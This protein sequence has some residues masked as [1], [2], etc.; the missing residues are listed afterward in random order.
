[1]LQSEPALHPNQGCGGC[2][3]SRQSSTQRAARR[4]S[5]GALPPS[6]PPITAVQS[7]EA[8]KGGGRDTQTGTERPSKFKPSPTKWASKAELVTATW[9]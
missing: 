9:R 8:E 2:A 1:M 3:W 4:V 7:K 5:L 6:H